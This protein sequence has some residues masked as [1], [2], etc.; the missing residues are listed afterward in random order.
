MSSTT[1]PL[2][3][4]SFSAGDTWINVVTEVGLST[5]HQSS[6]G[7][8]ELCTISRGITCVHLYLS[9][10]MKL[11]WKLHKEDN[12]EITMQNIRKDK[13]YL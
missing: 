10:F 2:Q 4:G 6:P 3:T 11:H 13:S 9:R 5:S 1:N 7:M 12:H 8:A